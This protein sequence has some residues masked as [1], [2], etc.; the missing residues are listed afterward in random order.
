MGLPYQIDEY[1]IIWE[2]EKMKDNVNNID[3]ICFFIICF[4]FEFKSI[5]FKIIRQKLNNWNRW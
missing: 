1:V 2:N 4:F 3:S 5:W